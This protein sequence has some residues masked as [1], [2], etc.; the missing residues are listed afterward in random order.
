[1][2]NIILGSPKAGWDYTVQTAWVYQLSDSLVLKD[3]G[4]FADVSATPP[5]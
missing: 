3:L 1:M 4:F 5:K 2:E